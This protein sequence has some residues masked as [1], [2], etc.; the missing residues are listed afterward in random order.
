M[1]FGTIFMMTPVCGWNLP[2]LAPIL[3]ATAGAM[4]Y[5]RLTALPARKRMQGKLEKQLQNKR[6]IELNLEDY[7]K[8]VVSEQLDHE[9][10]IQF[11]KDDLVLAFG[12]DVR[13]RFFIRVTGPKDRTTAELRYLGEEFALAVIQQFAYNRIASELD[14]RGVQ[15]VEETTDEEGNIVLRTRRW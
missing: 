2:L 4:G 3:I 7:L 14:R 11:E 6:T 12:H 9:E 8:G 5:R 10:E 15:V 13:G 1:A